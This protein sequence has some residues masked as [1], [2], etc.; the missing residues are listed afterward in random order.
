MDSVEI[1]LKEYETL[2]Q[3]SLNA[4]NNRNIILSF[5]LA[6]IGAIFTGSIVAYTTGI[7]SI[8]PSLALILLIPTINSF[9]LFMWLG[10]YER[11]HRAGKFL[12]ELEHKINKENKKEVLTWETYLRKSQLHMKYPYESTVLLLIVISGVSVFFG[13]VK[14][15]FSATLMWSI[16]IAWILTHFGMCS[17]VTT[18]L[19]RLRL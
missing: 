15:D 11:M 1:M 5:G 17:I 6:T 10:E 14:A 2:R 18:H 13:L 3:E 16:A 7:Y 12:V 8:I 4:M 19:S 9:V